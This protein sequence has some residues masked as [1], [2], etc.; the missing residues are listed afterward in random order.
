MG[1]GFSFFSSF[2][3]DLATVLNTYA[4]SEPEVLCNVNRNYVF[5]VIVESPAIRGKTLT[6][7]V[8]V[9]VGIVYYG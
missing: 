6:T 5:S 8:G 4:Q 2:A 9:P 3:T 1:S 7:P